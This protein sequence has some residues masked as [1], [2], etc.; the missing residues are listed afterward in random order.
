L[1]LSTARDVRA[2]DLIP[3][4]FVEVTGGGGVPINTVQWGNPQ[5]PPIL[6]ISAYSQ[7]YLNFTAQMEDTALAREFHLI[8]FDLRGHGASGKPWDEASYADTKPWADDVAAII[9][10]LGLDRPT[11]VAWS[12]GGV[13]AMD[14]VRHYGANDIAAINFVGTI[15]GFGTRPAPETSGRAALPSK[16]RL[17]NDIRSSIEGMPG[18]IDI[19]TF[20]PLPADFRHLML[21]SNMMTPAYVRRAILKH[22]WGNDDL[23]PRMTMPV[24]FSQGDKD[25]STKM[26]SVIALSKRLPGS[27]V[28][29]FKDT[30]T[31]PFYEDTARF[32]RELAEFVRSAQR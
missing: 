25:P 10:A 1:R 9:R 17:S 6:F 13:V 23:L 16:G 14:Y 3:L 2:A 31:S 7:T 26:D 30:A 11:L 32:D 19:L 18:L 21:M 8:A 15:A 22:P 29:V 28:S 12:F 24:L 4:K 20:K 27:R 5:G